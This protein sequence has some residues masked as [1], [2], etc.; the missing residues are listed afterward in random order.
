MSQNQTNIS[1]NLPSESE[2]EETDQTPVHKKCFCANHYDSYMFGV[3]DFC[4]IC[5]ITGCLIIF[6][7]TGRL[8]NSVVEEESDEESDED[9]DEDSE[10]SE[11]TY[12]S[13][14]PYAYITGFCEDCIKT[15]NCFDCYQ[16]NNT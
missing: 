11:D 13:K 3:K 9:S 1:K 5:D 6:K 15:V 7:Y 12:R 2:E 8:K 14:K 10:E 4:D 16:P